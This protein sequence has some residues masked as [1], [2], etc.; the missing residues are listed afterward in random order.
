MGWKPN[1]PGCA[2][3]A[4][5]LACAK[6]AGA[7]DAELIILCLMGGSRRKDAYSASLL[8]FNTL[9][10]G[11]R[12]SH[13]FLLCSVRAPRSCSSLAPRSHST[14]HTQHTRGTA[15]KPPL[16]HPFFILDLSPIP[17]SKTPFEFRNLHEKEERPN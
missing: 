7:S 6:N 13:P 4:P 16:S 9:A 5:N 11:W 10:A 3:G 15:I 8:S 2:V 1:W 17:S 14:P 12:R